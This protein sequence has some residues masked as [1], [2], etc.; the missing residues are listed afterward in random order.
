MIFF[1]IVKYI[2]IYNKIS[3]TCFSTNQFYH[4][5]YSHSKIILILCNYF[6]LPYR[7]IICNLDGY[8]CGFMIKS[9][10]QP[11]SPKHLYN[12]I[13]SIYYYNNKCRKLILKGISYYP[14]I[15]P[16]T[17]FYPCLELSLSPNSGL[18]TYLITVLMISGCSPS[19][20]KII[21]STV[22]GKLY[23]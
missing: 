20:L 22:L 13:L 4:F 11:V 9:G 15:S 1:L 8:P 12:Y 17:P 16:H 18:R 21:L 10:H 7:Y 23:L 14:T 2:R 3:N 19:L 5:P 6:N